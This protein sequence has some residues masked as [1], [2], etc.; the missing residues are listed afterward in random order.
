MRSARRRFSLAGKKR[1]VGESDQLH[2]EVSRVSGLR[3]ALILPQPLERRHKVTDVHGLAQEDRVASPLR[4]GV[5]LDT[6]DV[7]DGLE[8]PAR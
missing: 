7:N 4:G 1:T 3:P 8:R 5:K 2:A 6:G